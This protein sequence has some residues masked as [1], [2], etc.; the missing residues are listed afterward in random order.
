M[1]RSMSCQGF[2]PYVARRMSLRMIVNFS[3]NLSCHLPLPLEAEAC[4]GDDEDAPD[5]TSDLQ[6]L[7][8]KSR[9]NRLSGA[10]VVGQK[11]SDAGELEEILVDRFKL[12]GKWVYPSD[13]KTEVRI[14]IRRLVPD[15][16]PR[17]RVGSGMRRRRRGALPGR[18]VGRRSRPR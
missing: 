1:H 6:F 3:R 16:E 18:R 14:G 10:R 5:Q 4:G 7:D 13:R 15:G 9:H 12:V 2:A 17:S 8:Q 11:E